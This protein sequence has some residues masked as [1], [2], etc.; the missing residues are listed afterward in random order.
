MLSVESKAAPLVCKLFAQGIYSC[1]ELRI[2]ILYIP[3]ILLQGV[4]SV[5]C[6]DLQVFQARMAVDEPWQL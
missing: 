5:L 2:E 1:H 4:D 6:D 3:Q